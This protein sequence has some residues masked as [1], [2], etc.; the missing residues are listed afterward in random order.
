MARPLAKDIRERVVAAVGG[1]ASTRAVAARFGVA[2]SSVVK[3]SAAVSRD[4]LRCARQDGRAPQGRAGGASCVHHGTAASDAASDVARLEGRT[5]C[6]RGQNLAQCDLAVPASGG[7]A[8]QKKHCSPLSRPAKM[9]PAGGDAGNP[10][11]PASIPA[12]W[13]PRRDLDHDLHG[14]AARMGR[15]RAP[16]F[17]SFAPHGHWRT[18]TFL[19]A[20][21]CDRLTAPCVFDGPIDGECFRAYV[22]QELVPGPRSQATSSSWTISAATSRQRSAA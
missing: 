19:G 3:W 18:M 13:S 1:G 15:T 4:R 20:L 17:G 10:G 12:A 5:G 7:T 21:R 8:L 9:S 11:R 22:E 16:G 2:L 6:A 14:P